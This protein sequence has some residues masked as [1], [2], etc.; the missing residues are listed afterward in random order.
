M[1]D[2]SVGGSGVVASVELVVGSATGLGV[3]AGEETCVPFVRKGITSSSD[4]TP[5]A[6]MST[7]KRQRGIAEHAFITKQLKQGK[8]SAAKA[9]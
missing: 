4:V 5:M 2:S 8:T 6:P 3:E 7:T 9:P 1:R